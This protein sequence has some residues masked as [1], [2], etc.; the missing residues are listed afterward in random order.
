M[1]RY[2]MHM[3]MY[4]HIIHVHI[5]MCMYIYTYI[6]IYIYMYMYMYI[7]IYIY[8]RGRYLALRPRV[9]WAWPLVKS[10]VLPRRGRRTSEAHD[11]AVSKRLRAFRAGTRQGGPWCA[12]CAFPATCFIRFDRM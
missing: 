9:S 7:N 4:I 3:H 11:S 8:A 10:A 12:R 2:Y 1:I 5:Y 6:Y